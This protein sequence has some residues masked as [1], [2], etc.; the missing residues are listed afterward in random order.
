MAYVIK[1]IPIMAQGNASIKT[2]T[3]MPQSEAKMCKK[4]I[5]NAEA[6]QQRLEVAAKIKQ[7][8]EK[9]NAKQNDI[10]KESEAAK[11]YFG[12]K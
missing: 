3:C 1:N 12:I 11:A 4:H 9:E 10:I 5:Y 2:F 6:I 7:T 8:L